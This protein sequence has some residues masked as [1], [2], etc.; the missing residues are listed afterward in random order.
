MTKRT[1]YHVERLADLLRL[2]RPAPLAWVCRA[3]QIPLDHA[4]GPDDVGELMRKL[5]ADPTFR[6]RFDD[7]PVGATAEAGLDGLAVQLQDE[8]VS[9]AAVVE[10]IAADESYRRELDDDP[11]T[12]LGAAGLPGEAV[13]DFL[14]TLGSMEMALTKLPEV[15]AHRNERRR[16]RVVLLTL[17]IGTRRIGDELRALMT[18]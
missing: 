18:P 6:Q 2:L 4:V 9:L 11:V 7:D 14:E 15:A 3:Q 8:W 13:E 16:P 12:T 17:L 5:E 1:G 10:R